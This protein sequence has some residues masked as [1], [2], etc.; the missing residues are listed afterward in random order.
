MKRQ[1]GRL[2][3]RACLL[4]G[5]CHACVLF[6]AVVESE[7]T[8]NEG[9][10]QDISDEIARLNRLMDGYMAAIRDVADFHRTCTVA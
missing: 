7:F 8:E 10:M 2:C 6:V 4:P 5:C 1:L 9:T 3:S